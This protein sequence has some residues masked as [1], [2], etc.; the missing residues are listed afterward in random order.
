P[1]RPANLSMLYPSVRGRAT[2]T[3]G[4]IELR[5]RFRPFASPARRHCRLPTAFPKKTSESS[6]QDMVRLGTSSLRLFYGLTAVTSRVAAQGPAANQERMPSDRC[7]VI[8]NPQA[9]SS[10]AYVRVWRTSAISSLPLFLSTRVASPSA[11]ARS[12]RRAHYESPA[13]RP[14]RRATR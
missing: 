1:I 12:P 9:S 5:P 2:W 6:V 10:L 7:S 11:L 13:S 4:Q 8:F 14:P 3:G